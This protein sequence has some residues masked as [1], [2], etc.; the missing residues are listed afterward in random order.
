ME[1]NTM[2]LSQ[3]KVLL[4]EGRA[5]GNKELREYLEIQAYA[6]AAHWVYDQ[7][8]GTDDW[9]G[10]DLINLT[11]LRKIHTLVVDP[12]WRHVPPPGQR[13][14][15]GPGSFR[16]HDVK[17]L[18]SGFTPP[19]WPDV[20]ALISD[21]LKT[22]NLRPLANIHPTVHLADVHAEFE[23]IH[24]F[25]DGNGRTGRLVLNLMLVRMGY[26]PA[27]IYKAQRM[28]YLRALR[29]ADREN[30]PFTLA[31]LLARAVKYSIDRFV[32]PGLAGPHRMVTLSALVGSGLSLVALRRAAMRGRLK[33]MRRRDQWVSTKQWVEEYRKSRRRGRRKAE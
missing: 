25:L 30:D 21:W 32:L 33:A 22:A 20:P 18:M 12:V 6:E 9:T 26:P 10:H 4:E 8:V 17:P 3:V 14:D 27:V 16:R 5:V 23:R 11:E 13:A 1:G 7:A 15:E 31:E 28:K 2:A 19:P 29:R 24:P